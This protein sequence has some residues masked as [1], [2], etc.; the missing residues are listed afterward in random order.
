MNV[1]SSHRLK[2]SKYFASSY[3][4]IVGWKVA[5]LSVWLDPKPEKN[6][7]SVQ[8]QESF[9]ARYALASGFTRQLVDIQQGSWGP[10]GKGTTCS[11]LSLNRM[12][13]S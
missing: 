7:D 9:R 6:W 1:G 13:F 8:P 3:K 4:K 2:H 12:N 11:L 5:I 10:A